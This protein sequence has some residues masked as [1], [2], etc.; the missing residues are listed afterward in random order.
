MALRAAELEVLFTADTKQIE[1]ADKDVQTIGRKIESKPIAAK[2]TADEKGAL[3]SMGR[4]EG[5]AKKLVS[6]D[7]AL[8]LDADVTRAERGLE[9]AKQRLADLEV[10]AL[11]GLDVTADV[12]RAEAG[13]QKIERNLAGLQ[14]A[15]TMI[16]VEADPTPAESRLSRFF[17]RFRSDADSAGQEGGKS[18]SKGLDTATRGAGQKVGEAVGGDIE[19]TLMS[20]LAAIPIAGGIVLAGVAIGKAINGAIQDGLQ[21]EVGNDRLQALTGIDEAD[22]LRLGRA[23]GQ[24][25]ANVFGDSVEANM[26]TTRLALQFDLIDAD[27]STKNARRVVEGLS[28]MLTCSVR[29]CSRSLPPSPPCSTLAWPARPRT[30]S[31]FLPPVRV[32]A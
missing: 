27:T 4:V 9:R 29:M 32:K 14:S 12:R 10:R 23:A 25:Y 15:R 1:K 17:S 2:V 3:A 22:A 20:A 16:E 31:T 19:G 18:F 13:L 11:G 30:L 21:V 28:G 5:A 26:D 6:Q 7:T 8:K 24:A